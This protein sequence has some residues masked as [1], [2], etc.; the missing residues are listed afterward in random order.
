MNSQLSFGAATA[1]AVTSV[2]PRLAP[3]LQQ[4]AR[5]LPAML[6]LDRPAARLHVRAFKVA[7]SSA[8]QPCHG[9]L[10]LLPSLGWAGHR[11]L[12]GGHEDV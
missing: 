12:L 6:D 11:D 1:I 10:S 9:Q 5:D 4:S 3:P 2:L 7:A 8:E